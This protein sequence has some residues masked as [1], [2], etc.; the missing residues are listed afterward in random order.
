VLAHGG[1]LT[2][3]SVEGEGTTVRFTLAAA[4][5]AA[6]QLPLPMEPPAE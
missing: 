6:D 2:I 4:G 1:E 5:A 3:D